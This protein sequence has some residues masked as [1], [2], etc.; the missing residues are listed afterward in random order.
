MNFI[1][2]A[3]TA[4][5]FIDRESVEHVFLFEK[6]GNAYLS[7]FQPDAIKSSECFEVYLN[8]KTQ[9]FIA[10]IQAAKLDEQV[11]DLAV[12]EFEKHIAEIHQ[13]STRIE[14]DKRQYLGHGDLSSTNVLV[15]SESIVFIDFLPN[16]EWLS[17]TSDFAKMYFSFS[18]G[19]E[20]HSLEIE[21][22][23]ELPQA[24]SSVF[25][26]S[27]F[28]LANE[29]LFFSKNRLGIQPEEMILQS[30][31]HL[32]RVIPYKLGDDKE[33]NQKWCLFAKQYLES[34]F[35]RLKALGLF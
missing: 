25:A 15:S 14:I 12:L 28:S 23:R 6:I 13:I 19:I 30:M 17:I 21:G 16:Q 4:E 27:R 34:E 35:S 1:S 10:S 11:R 26:V 31:V 7:T 22:S 3:M 2:S 32:F 20:R 9:R 18:S 29:F 33:M 8:N 5:E 24:R